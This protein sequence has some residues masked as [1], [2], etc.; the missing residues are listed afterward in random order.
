MNHLVQAVVTVLAVVNPIVSGAILM[1]IVSGQPRR[2]RILAATRAALTVLVILVVAALVGRFILKAFG[3]SMDTFQIVGGVIIAYLGFQM[4]GDGLQNND[5]K[6]DSGTDL[7]RLVMFAAS[8]GT[9]ATVVTLSAVH[10]AD[11]LPLTALIAVVVVVLI[12]WAVM[13]AMVTVSRGTPSQGKQFA[14]KFMG[15]IVIAMGLQF[16]LEGYKAFM[17]AT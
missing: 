6:K 2:N 13:V 14:T 10:T 16:A 8:P 15:L 1:E 9:I 3:I 12:T 5:D 17:S 7:S 4:M 11:G